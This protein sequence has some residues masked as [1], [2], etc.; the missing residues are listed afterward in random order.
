MANHSFPPVRPKKCQVY[1]LPSFGHLKPKMP[2]TDEHALRQ[3]RPPESLLQAW[4]K[5]MGL[6]RDF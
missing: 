3:N 2:C 6:D 1:V 4:R 5:A